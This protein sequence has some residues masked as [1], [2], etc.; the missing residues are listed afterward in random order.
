MVIPLPA[1][2]V[3]YLKDPGIMV[4]PEGA[5]G[6]FANEDD[7]DSDSEEV[8]LCTCREVFLSFLRI[9]SKNISRNILHTRFH[10]YNK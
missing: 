4:L 10:K 8:S 6:S 1:E 2:F 5:T 7:F 3:S 9:C